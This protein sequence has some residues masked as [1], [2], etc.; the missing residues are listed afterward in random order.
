MDG[1]L[2][3]GYRN[4]SSPCLAVCTVAKPGST[5]LGEID[6]QLVFMK[7][8]SAKDRPLCLLTFIGPTRTLSVAM[9]TLATTTRALLALKPTYAVDLA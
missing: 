2:K 3:V 1:R 9:H 7:P 8:G 4:I 5:K 6:P